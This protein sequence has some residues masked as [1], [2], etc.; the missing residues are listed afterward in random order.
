MYINCNGEL[1]SLETPKVMGILN[2]TPDSFF[3]SSR[4]TQADVLNR[5]EEMLSQGADFID[6]GGYSSRPNAKEVSQEEEL[7]RVISVV[8]SI[9]KHFPKIKLSVDTFRSEVARQSLLE[10][11]CIVNDISGGNLDN[12][13]F[14]VVAEFQVPYI[15]MHM[16]GTPQTMQS[17]TNYTNIIT[18]MIYYFSKIKAKTQSFGIND[19]IIDPGFGFSKT[20]DQNYEILQKLNLFKELDTPILVGISRKSMLY[21]L[22]EINSNEALNATSV[23]N[24]ISLMKG[25]NI[26][27]VHDV[28]EAKECVKIFNKTFNR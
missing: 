5:V 18:E 27:R 25:A 28:K 13:M 22:L 11:A 2:I 8:K 14:E 21:N 6:L 3:Q 24:T 16:V 23:V 17:H 19:V 1:I 4:V 9:V 26:L 10:G 20:L 7:E 15:A 12:Q